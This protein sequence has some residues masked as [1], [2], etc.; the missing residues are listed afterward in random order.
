MAVYVRDGALLAMEEINRSGGIMGHPLR[1]LVRNDGG[2]KEGIEKADLDLIGRG[3]IAIIGHRNSR[4]TLWAYPLVM[5]KGILLLSPACASSQLTGK[6]DLFIRTT[7]INDDL[8]E[9]ITRYFS[10]KHITNVLC[11]V[12]YSNEA[13]SL[14]LF[15]KL[16][17]HSSLVYYPFFVNTEKDNTYPL[18]AE[19]A[20]LSQPQAILFITGPAV[21]A[22][23]AQGVRNSGCNAPMYATSWAQTQDLFRYGGRAVVGMKIFSFVRPDTPY[24][25]FRHFVDRLERMGFTPNIRNALGYEAVMIIAEGLKRAK[26]LTPKALKEAMINNKFEGVIAPIPLNKYGDPCRPLWLLEL[27]ENGHMR[28]LRTLK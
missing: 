10:E 11:I 24:P 28:T 22:F 2:T 23:L 5:Q 25:P 7:F 19:L 9:K 13:F 15:E 1:L 21:T 17:K 12:D 6:D 3:V 14:D 8:G 18:L 20:V 27:F 26:E 4:D 16:K